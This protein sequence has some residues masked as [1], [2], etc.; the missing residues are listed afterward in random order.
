MN[1]T[2]PLKL[3]Q[4]LTLSKQT[5][6]FWNIIHKNFPKVERFGIGT[7]IDQTFLNYIEILFCLSYLP[8]EHKLPFLNKAIGK[9]D[10]LKFFTQMAWENKYIP[11]EKYTELLK[12]LEEIGRQLGCW[13]KGLETKNS[14]SN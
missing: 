5:Y 3:P 7:K 9:V 13:K 11:T 14:Q 12:S 1:N 10:I 8:K 2:P 4:V 6:S